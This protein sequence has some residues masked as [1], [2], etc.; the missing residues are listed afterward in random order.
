LKEIK[1]KLGSQAKEKLQRGEQLNWDEFQ[2]L[3]EDDDQ[4][5][6]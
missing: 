1:E 5:Q 2:L 4:T 6:D 3:A